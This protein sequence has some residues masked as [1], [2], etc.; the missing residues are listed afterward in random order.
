MALPDGILPDAAAES[1]LPTP[2]ASTAEAQTVTITM[3]RAAFEALSATISG[4]ADMLKQAGAKVQDDEAAAGAGELSDSDA[5]D[6]G[7]AAAG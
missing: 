4:F 5:I 1:A 6:Q 2:D 3:P 7:L